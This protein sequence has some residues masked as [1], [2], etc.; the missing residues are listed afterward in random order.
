MQSGGNPPNLLTSSVFRVEELG[1]CE[2]TRDGREKVS[3]PPFSG[4]G[5]DEIHTDVGATGL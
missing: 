5:M 1:K 2:T 4:N 3:I